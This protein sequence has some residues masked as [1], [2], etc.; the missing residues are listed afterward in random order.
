MTSRRRLGDLQLAILE[1]L[2]AR[3]EATVADVHQELHDSRGLA[4]TTIATMLRKMDDRGLVAHRREG[5]TFVYR[6]SV[7]RDAVHRSMVGDLIER[8][9][10]GDPKE[11]VH[12][13]LTE[14]ELDAE[15]LDDLRQRVAK[16][17]RR[18]GRDG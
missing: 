6:P 10:A 13:L 12:H 5:R 9:F 4:M 14:G 16:H 1:L 17:K 8:L 11:L 2:W 18:G 7:A 15:A 3:G